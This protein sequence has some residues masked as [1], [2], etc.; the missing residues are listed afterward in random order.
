MH[1]EPRATLRFALGLGVAAALGWG[2]GG[3]FA[4]LLPMLALFL[5]ASGGAP[6]SLRQ[7]AALVVITAVSCLWG[8][9]LAPM[10]TYAAPAGVLLILGGVAAA[11]YL[12]TRMPALAVP[13]KLFIVGN[14]LIAVLAY[15]S[16]ALAMTVAVELLVDVVLA[17]AIAW[18]AFILLPDKV[19]DGAATPPPAPVPLAPDK[20]GWIAMRSA[21]VMS[22][23][24]IFALDNPG[25]FLMTLVN[26]AQLAQQSNAAQVRQNG[27]M[28][29]TSTLAGSAMAA[30]FWLALGLWPTL[31]LLAGGMALAA[32][33][34]GPRLHAAG[35]SAQAQAKAQ[36]WW[37]SAMST[38]IVV[39]GSAA[40]DSAT[41]DGIWTLMLR[42]VAV[43]LALTGAA[44]VMVMI[45]DQWRA[46]R[47]LVRTALATYGE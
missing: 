9:L 22:L 25:L 34:I 15:Q 11:A 33:I 8:V 31:L 2:R 23:P 26:G 21:L 1:I 24:V 41:G 12:S 32:L 28:I 44:A 36:V 47:K 40:S 4:Y 3:P 16:Q 10:L 14:T 20:A 5:L 6:P 17:V 43:M 38:M 13:L 29:V 19:G 37:P 35:A 27:T 18:G 42:R 45:L 30:V 39:L 7:A 46:R